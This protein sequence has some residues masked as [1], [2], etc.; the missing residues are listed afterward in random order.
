[1]K[2]NLANRLIAKGINRHISVIDKEHALAMHSLGQNSGVLHRG[3][4]YKPNALKAHMCVNGAMQL[5]E[6]I[7]KQ[8]W[9]SSNT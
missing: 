5:G 3:I 1:L 8:I 4:Y 2:L 9:R 7:P 6:F